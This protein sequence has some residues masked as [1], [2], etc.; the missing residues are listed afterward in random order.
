MAY[1][2]NDFD[3]ELSHYGRGELHFHYAKSYRLSLKCGLSWFD[4]TG[5]SEDFPSCFP[6]FTL[7]H[8]FVH[9]S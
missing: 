4:G 7:K 1:M 2:Y 8:K 6:I 9:V 5:I 3:C